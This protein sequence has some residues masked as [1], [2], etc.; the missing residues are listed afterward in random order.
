MFTK[1]TVQRETFALTLDSAVSVS[2]MIRRG[3]YGYVSDDY[4][5]ANLNL[6]LT[7]PREVVLFDSKGS[8]YS[9]EMIARM[10]AEG[11][12]PATIDDALAMGAQFPDRQKEN[13]IVFLG[14]T[15]AAP[16]RDRHV[17]VLSRWEARR[18]LQ[19]H[20]FGHVWHA[21]CRFAAVRE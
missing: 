4:A 12:V 21:R 3:N 8:V 17:P 18:E 6:T 13:A 2:E 5:P 1:T 16:G 7:G 14:T 20:W 9:K 10:K 11:Y 19:L 15:W